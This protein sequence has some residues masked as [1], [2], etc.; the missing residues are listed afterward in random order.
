[1]RACSS[2]CALALLACGCS[3]HADPI[4]VAPTRVNPLARV[5]VLTHHNDNARTG[6]NLRESELTPDIVRTSFGPLFTLFADG[7]IYAQPLIVADLDLGPAGSH[8]VLYVATEHDTLYAFDANAAA[9]PLWQRSLGRASNLNCF[10]EKL[11]T[12]EI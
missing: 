6:A 5:S 1:M 9:P 10:P 11:L 3:D 8:D 12:P 2:L 7:L 4:A